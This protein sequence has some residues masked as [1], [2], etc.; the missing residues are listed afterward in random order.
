M[1]ERAERVHWEINR[2]YGFDDSFRLHYSEGGKK[3]I[4][5]LE[6]IQDKELCLGVIDN[7]VL[8]PKRLMVFD[9]DREPIKVTIPKTGDTIEFGLQGKSAVIIFE[10]N[11]CNK[12]MVKN[13]V[14][15]IFKFNPSSGRHLHA[16]SVSEI[17]NAGWVAYWAPLQLKH[18]IDHVRL[19]AQST[20]HQGTDPTIEEA[21]SLANAFKKIC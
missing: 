13:M 5:P 8:K 18:L 12:E 10:P 14:L 15:A 17:E 3:T 21:E 9:K 2:P 1:S 11:V 7:S 6:V 20:I 19:V 16:T 4:N